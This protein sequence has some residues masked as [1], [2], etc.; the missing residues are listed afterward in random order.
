MKPLAT[1]PRSMRGSGIRQ[2]MNLALS[3]DGVKHVEVGEPDFPT[4][5]H[6]VEAAYAAA[7]AGYTK[8]T[9]NAG[10][11]S[12]REALAEKVRRVNGDTVSPDRITVTCGAVSGLMA[13]VMALAEAGDEILLPDPGWPNYEMMTQTLG[14]VS[15]RYRLDPDRDFL[16]DGAEID[17]LVTPRTKAIVLNTP[18]NPTGAV[19]PERTVADLMQVAERHDLW[20]ISD[21]VYDQII[22]DRPH[23]SPARFDPDGRVLRVFS[24]SK[25]YAMTGWR[26]GYVV[27][28]PGVTEVI[29][30]LQ[31][32]LISC[33]S[34]V[35]QKAAEAAVLG[36]Q[37]C[38][39]V[40]RSAYQRRRDLVVEHLGGSGL[41]AAVPHGAFYAMIDI[42]AVT[43]DTYEFARRLLLEQQVAVAPGET[44]GPGGHGL[45]RIALCAADETIVHAVDAIMREVSGVPVE[46]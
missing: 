34:A 45:V 46:S 27:S 39:E 8:Y 25:T 24:L 12:V 18:S 36:P 21:E 20:V 28:P 13:A 17:A 23:I 42:S 19:F 43:D 41:L 3:M 37:D 29:N 40:M 35:S 22:F 16:P 30:K 1:N 10:I 5:P 31:E 33:A 26:V 2:I 44:F 4:P 32:A 14:V 6:I 9:A 11:P 7:R 15:K 38:V